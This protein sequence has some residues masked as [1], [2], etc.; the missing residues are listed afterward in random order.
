M[1]LLALPP[2]IRLRIYSLLFPSPKSHIILVP[3]NHSNPECQFDIPLSLYG[4][5]KTV[6]KDLLPLR[7]QLRSLELVYIIHFYVE[8]GE[9]S[10]TVE[11]ASAQARHFERMTRVAESVRVIGCDHK[12]KLCWRG[13]PLAPSLKGDCVMRTIEV[14]PLT[15]SAR[16][17]WSGLKEIL[18]PLIW[19]SLEGLQLKLIREGYHPGPL[20]GYAL[21]KE[22]NEEELDMLEQ[23]FQNWTEM[24]KD[25]KELWNSWPRVDTYRYIY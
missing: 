7:E 20:G 24:K 18:K 15:T 22:E 10:P 21:S 13:G 14:Q 9:V 11:T 23:V 1:S 17:M 6:Y 25:G 19:E 5:C 16:T 8:A 4:V 3:Y 12:R 2:E